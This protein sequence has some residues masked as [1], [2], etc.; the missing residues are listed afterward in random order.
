MIP[1]SLSFP[2]SLSLYL[3]LS[4]SI[5]FLGILQVEFLVLKLFRLHLRCYINNYFKTYNLH[6]GENPVRFSSQFSLEWKHLSSDKTWIYDLNTPVLWLTPR[7]TTGG[8]W[9]NYQNSTG[10][11]LFSLAD[12][13]ILTYIHFSIILNIEI[14]ICSKQ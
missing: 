2:L 3:S 6:S 9:N 10:G 14:I 4:L 7:E 12:K 5:S 1:F 13:T 11:K 8:V